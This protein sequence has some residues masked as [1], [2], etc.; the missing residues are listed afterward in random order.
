MSRSIRS[1]KSGS[2]GD[3]GKL[4]A[5][6]GMAGNNI[7]LFAV[8]LMG[9][10]LGMWGS[11][12]SPA[13]SEIPNSF[14]DPPVPSRSPLIPG[15]APLAALLGWIRPDLCWYRSGFGAFIPRQG[16]RWEQWSGKCRGSAQA[17]VKPILGNK[18]LLF[19]GMF[20][21]PG[22]GVTPGSSC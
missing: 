1:Y 20:G 11:S 12:A 22:I 14:L 2:S 6:Q 15:I 18:T 5:C 21:S 7:Y 13:R 4:R 8:A 17:G 9:F 10:F 19:S 16:H 3:A